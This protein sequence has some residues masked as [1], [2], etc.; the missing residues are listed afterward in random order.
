MPRLHQP[1]LPR[2]DA[3]SLR[4]TKSGPIS[5]GIVSAT[6]VKGPDR[7][8]VIVRQPVSFVESDQRVLL[9]AGCGRLF[10]TAN[11]AQTRCS[12]ACADRVEADRD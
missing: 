1:A 4:T 7:A 10:R 11:T 2:D 3:P 5:G 9:C 12:L 8:L 6:H